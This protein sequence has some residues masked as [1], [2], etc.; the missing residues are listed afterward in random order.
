MRT[1]FALV[2]GYLLVARLV[3][4]AWS[5]RQE[6]RLL[7]R[8]GRR[9]ADDGMG[10]LVAVHVAWLGGLLVEELLL[11]PADLPAGVR[12]AAAAVFVGAEALRL[13]AIA[14]LG[15]RWNVRVVVVDGEAPVE[16]GPYRWLRHPNYV[17]VVVSIVALPLALALPWTPAL[18]LAPK[19]LALRR[20][21]EVE[22][23][24]LYGAG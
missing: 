15:E 16:R 3:E 12:A 24:A 19:L 2:F 21:L 4:L 6:R 11:G 7:A 10:A 17:A 14:T 23:R 5:R 13:W 18:T 8:G 1:V 20:R 22:N 9:L